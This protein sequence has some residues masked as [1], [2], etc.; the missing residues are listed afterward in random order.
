[1]TTPGQPAPDGAF[2]IG[3]GGTSTG[4]SYGQGLTDPAAAHL[5]LGGFTSIASIANPL[6]AVTS[7][8]SMFADALLKLPL[9][10]LK[11]F[12]PLIPGD[13]GDLFSTVGGAVQA[14]IGHFQAIGPLLTSTFNSFI[15]TTYNILSSAVQQVLDIF[16][17]LVVT[18]INSAIQ[19]VKDWF[20]GITANI[21]GF[22]SDIFGINTLIQNIINTIWSA[23]KGLPI[24]GG[25]VPDLPALA[26]AVQTQ[27]VNQQ[28]ATIATVTN[29]G[30]RNPSWVCR[31]P[32]ADVTFPEILNAAWSVYG[33]TGAAST[34]TAHTHTLPGADDAYAVKVLQPIM[35]NE[36]RFGVITMTNTGV[37]DTLAAAMRIPSGTI[38]NVFLELLRIDTAAG[39]AK[40][41]ASV[42]IASLIPVGTEDFVEAPITPVIAQAGESYLLKIRNSTNNGNYVQVN[43]LRATS[44]ATGKYAMTTSAS[45][46]TNNTTYNSTQLTSI[47]NVGGSTPFGMVAVKNPVPTAQSFSDDFNR[48]GIGGLWYPMSNTGANQIDITSSRAGFQSTTNGDQVGLY[49]KPVSGNQ[50]LVEAN[51]YD[52]VATPR[53]GVMSCC[54]RELTEGVYLGVNASTANIYTGAWGSLTQRKTISV[55][56]GDAKWGLYNDPSAAKFIVLRDG[57]DVGSWIDT[58][59]V[60]H[61]GAEFRYG[62]IRITRASGVNAGTLDNW[63]LRDYAA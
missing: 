46:L 10:V 58:G 9:D 28:N 35:A 24:V 40:T 56:G 25:F 31:Y 63:L 62:G 15:N 8:M 22:T 3:G 27:Q 42:N 61:L 12:E 18:P 48:V 32:I 55:T 17:G 59:G 36:A 41:V 52:R 13:L 23:L 37:L 2:V 33:V 4:S 47:M 26:N 20:N 60:V 39:T 16:N 21:F 30:Y 54:N 34:G 38:N 44:A 45:G 51:V 19:G 5:M 50:M 6:E 43:A 14:I 57:T 49:I 53:L 29:G 7:A 11:L 1:M